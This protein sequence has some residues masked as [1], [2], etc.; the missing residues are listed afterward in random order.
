[1]DSMQRYEVILGALLH[2]IGKFFQR[3]TPSDSEL[4]SISKGMENMLCPSLQ[5]RYTHRH[6]LFTNEFCDRYLK[7]LPKGLNKDSV[8]NLASYHHRP[9]NAE[10]EIIHKAD[11]LS[12]GMEREED[13]EY[14]GGPSV[15]RRVRLRPV[16]NEVRIEGRNL[17]EKGGPWA[18]PW[19]ISI[20]KRHFLF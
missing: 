12:S 19:T 11:M 9:G 13:E 15:F 18:F 16:M 2:D 17:L 3:S 1:M 7:N 8:T 20:P 14:P 4:S 6:V 10:Q 5:G